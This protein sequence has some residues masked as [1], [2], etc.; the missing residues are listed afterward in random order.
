MNARQS[1][2][3]LVANLNNQ[4]VEIDNNIES[5]QARHEQLETENAALLWVTKTHTNFMKHFL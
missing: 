4:L 1:N 3:D 5:L 2:S